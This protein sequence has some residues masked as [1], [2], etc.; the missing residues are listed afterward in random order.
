MIEFLFSCGG[1]AADVLVWAIYF[2]AFVGFA[3]FLIPKI[4]NRLRGGF[5]F[6]TYLFKEG[7]SGSFYLVGLILAAAAAL[8]PPFFSLCGWQYWLISALFGVIAVLFFCV[9]EIRRIHL[10]I[11]QANRLSYLPGLIFCFNDEGEKKKLKLKNIGKGIAFK[12]VITKI[13]EKEF[14]KNPIPLIDTD[15]VNPNLEK[16]DA[17]IHQNALRELEKGWNEFNNFEKKND[18]EGMA[19]TIMFNCVNESYK[20][21]QHTQ[22]KINF[23]L[24]TTK[25]V[26]ISWH[27]DYKR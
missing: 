17:R 12:P 26:G 5:D 7:L 16:C 20:S 24:G 1:S 2:I 19:V 14:I 3:V 6:K 8:L 18:E 15:S 13:N 22:Q 9:G 10:E 25:I 4:K 11:H 27:A 21:D 23:S